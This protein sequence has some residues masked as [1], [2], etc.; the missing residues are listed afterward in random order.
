[1]AT[2]QAWPPRTIPPPQIQHH[3]SKGMQNILEA[4]QNVTDASGQEAGSGLPLLSSEIFHPSSA[5]QFM[6]LRFLCEG[7]GSYLIKLVP[8]QAMFSFS[9]QTKHPKSPPASHWQWLNLSSE[10]S[11]GEPEIN[12]GKFIRGRAEGSSVV[13]NCFMGQQCTPRALIWLPL[14]PCAPTL[15]ISLS[16]SPFTAFNFL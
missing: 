4:E 7:G 1:M 14:I 2:N 15:S 5:Q 12:Q 3:L 16:L 13:R 8:S 9:W 11:P 10:T 6:A